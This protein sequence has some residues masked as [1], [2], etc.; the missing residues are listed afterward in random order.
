M[1]KR[2]VKRLSVGFV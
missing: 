1:A 2:L